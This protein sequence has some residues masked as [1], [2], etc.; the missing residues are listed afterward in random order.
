[1]WRSAL[2]YASVRLSA[3]LRGADCAPETGRRLAI[4]QGGEPAC[5]PASLGVLN[6]AEIA[7][8]FAAAKPVSEVRD[9]AADEAGDFASV[10]AER[11]E[12]N[13]SRDEVS[14]SSP[15]DADVASV[16]TLTADLS[17]SLTVSSG[18]LASAHGGGPAL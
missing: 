3:L 9:D 14:S 13:E 10:V 4:R 7:N 5:I 6:L 17:S 18:T 15:A 16:E 12:A 1:M 11:S 8:G 2:L